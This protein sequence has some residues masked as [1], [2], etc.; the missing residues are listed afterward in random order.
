M[1]I[2]FKFAIAL[3]L[4]SACLV[5]SLFSNAITTKRLQAEV[6][7]HRAALDTIVS[8]AVYESLEVS[9]GGNITQNVEISGADVQSIA[10]SNEAKCEG[11]PMQASAGGATCPPCDEKS[12]VEEA[13]NKRG[14]NV[15]NQKEANATP[16]PGSGIQDT[17]QEFEAITESQ[18]LTSTTNDALVTDTAL[19]ELLEAITDSENEMEISV[20]LGSSPNAQY[21]T[22]FAAVGSILG[23][24]A[25][26][27][28]GLRKHRIDNEALKNDYTR[29]AME[30]ESYKSR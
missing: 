5:I 16:S 3:L 2:F 30:I 27:F 17:S 1:N 10:A 20:S 13:E 23:T 22:S 14:V 6:A 18:F 19:N 4:L 21:W 8:R 25:M 9:A 24:F 28:L 11:M 15:S 12:E 26:F 7:S 29:L